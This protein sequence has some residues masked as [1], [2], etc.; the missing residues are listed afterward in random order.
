MIKILF[1]CKKRSEYS[2]ACC[3]KPNQKYGS[4]GLINSCKLVKEALELLYPG[5]VECKVVSV[6]D[7]NGIDKEVFNYKPSHVMIEALWVVPEKFYE[8]LPMH[9]GVQ[10]IV[11]IHSKIPFLANEG[12]AFSW[13]NGYLKIA[14]RFQNFH[15]AAN[16]GGFVENMIAAFN[17]DFLYLP[18]IYW[19]DW[20]FRI[21]V[22]SREE[23]TLNVGCFGAIR[24]MKNQLQQA[25][26]AILLAGEMRL[27]LRFHMNGI[28]EQQGDNVLKNI[29]ALMRDTGNE[30]VLHGWYPHNDFL[31]LVRQ[32]DIGLQVSL[33]ES[34]NIVTADFVHCNVPVVVSHDIAWANS[35]YKTDANCAVCIKEKMH[36]ALTYAHLNF[37]YLNKLALK[38]YNKQ[39]VEDWVKYLNIA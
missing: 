38:K 37:Q 5:R 36:F 34:F 14:A 10:W 1:I 13:I 33:S 8:L 26:A 11:R 25:L 27:K 30:L 39:A 15:V 7:N 32:M 18:N 6:T 9:K 2:N 17:T 29:K 4:Y 22:K 16:D 3:G 21:P 19:G 23:G 35:L 28:T 24:P 31:Q 12:I 20:S